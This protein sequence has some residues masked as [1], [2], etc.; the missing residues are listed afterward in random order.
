MGPTDYGSVTVRR[1]F[2]SKNR[3]ST[4]RVQAVSSHKPPVV[5]ILMFYPLSGKNQA[6]PLCGERRRG[7][8]VTKQQQISFQMEMGVQ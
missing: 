6:E 8:F 5:Y 2:I 4:G 7:A 1:S 3:I